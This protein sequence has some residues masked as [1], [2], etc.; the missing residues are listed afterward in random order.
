MANQLLKK[1]GL[2]FIGNAASKVI[3]AAIIPVYAYF[4][5]PEAL[6]NY[7]YA[8]TLTVIL[9]PVFFLALWEA[10]LRFLI[11]EQDEA[12]I[13]KLKSNIIVCV[14]FMLLILII[15]CVPVIIVLPI[16]PMISGFVTSMICVSGLAQIWQY[17]ARSF[18]DR[19]LYVISGIGS[20]VVNL[21]MLFVLVC[22]LDLQMVGLCVSYLSG[23]F[24]VVILIES[25]LQLMKGIKFALIDTQTIKKLLSFSA[26]LA[27]NLISLALLTGFGRILIT[28]TLGSEANG[29]YAFAMK[30]AAL[31]SAVG[32]V[33]TMAAIEEAILRV[34][35]KYLK[36]YF[37]RLLNSLWRIALS[38]IIIALPAIWVFYFIIGST[39]YV[40][41]FYL[42]PAFLLFAVF[43]LLSTNYG[44]IF[45]ATNTTRYIAITT[46]IGTMVTIILSFILIERC[47]S[48]GVAISLFLGAMTMLLMR[49]VLSRK[50]VSY[51]INCKV[52]VVLLALYAL[53][54]WLLVIGVNLFGNLTVISSFFLIVPMLF[55]LYREYKNMKN[56]PDIEEVQWQSQ[57]LTINDEE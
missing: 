22:L 57:Q 29:E 7:D 38:L 1:T 10:V 23:Q 8:L 44:N 24:F 17:F 9:A 39:D 5:N 50:F 47:G 18:H 43:S 11:D 48:L 28:N 32:S 42:V 15:I 6:G 19:N 12:A 55:V 54:W 33:F 4:V 34:N 27:L 21:L 46:I 41:S 13:E 3:Q 16:D 37:E 25:R 31:I 14:L 36:S 40:T 20:A 45:A 51:H 49:W 26:P 30:F 2:Y 56:I 35:T 53:E 52:L